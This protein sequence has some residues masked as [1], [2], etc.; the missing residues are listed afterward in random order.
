MG[1][2]QVQA[3]TNWWD[4]ICHFF[5][6]NDYYRTENGG[7][8]VA[9]GDGSVFENENGEVYVDGMD[10]V[11]VFGSREDDKFLISNSHVRY[12]DGGNGNDYIEVYNCDVDYMNGG[13]GDDALVAWNSDVKVMDGYIGND[14]LIVSGGRVGYMNGGNGDDNL[15]TQRG[16]QVGMIDG[17]YGLFSGNDRIDVYGSSVN[18]IEGRRGNDVININESNVRDIRGGRGRDTINTRHSRVGRVDGGRSNILLPFWFD[19]LFPQDTINSYDSTIG[20]THRARR[21]NY[22][23]TSYCGTF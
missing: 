13:N 19:F 6:G 20:R 18:R 16:A 8:I 2:N 3:N 23:H 21:H 22:S 5:T 17:G 11:S 7:R 15:Y 12:A 10:E 4:K 14:D 1:C 9:K